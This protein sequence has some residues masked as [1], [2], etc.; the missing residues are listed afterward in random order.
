MRKTP[1]KYIEN[2][3]RP[4]PHTGEMLKALYKKRRIRKAALARKINRRAS[5]LA[6]FAKNHTIQTAVLWELSHALKHNFFADIAAQLPAEYAT[7]VEAN[8]TN[9]DRIT[10]LERQVELLEAEKNVLLLAFKG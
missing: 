10:Q 2:T 9:S 5:T 4:A 7:N 6:S 1:Q 3:E 8:T